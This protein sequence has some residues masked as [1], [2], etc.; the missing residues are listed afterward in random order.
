MVT[1]GSVPVRENR[2]ACK[3]AGPMPN[4]IPERGAP[5]MLA[6]PR[7]R[8]GLRRLARRRWTPTAITGLWAA[9]WSFFLIASAS[10]ESHE[11]LGAGVW[12]FN[13]AAPMFVFWFAFMATILWRKAATALLLV[14]GLFVL[15][16]YPIQS[17]P[18]FGFWTTAFVMATLGLPPLMAGLLLLRRRRALMQTKQE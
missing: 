11:G 8:F 7:R 3:A 10:S 2:G 1:S 5:A 13:V 12:V 9:W 14:V 4:K 6:I 17:G 15:I 16:G 18:Q